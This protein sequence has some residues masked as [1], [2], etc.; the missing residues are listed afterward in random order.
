MQRLKKT[1]L[2][3][4]CLTLILPLSGRSQYKDFVKKETRS[5]LFEVAFDKKT[6][7][8][9]AFE[10]EG[11]KTVVVNRTDIAITPSDVIISTD[12]S[13]TSAGLNFQ[14]TSLPYSNITDAFISDED[15]LTTVTFYS[16]N[17]PVSRTNQMHGG[18]IISF[19]DP[20]SVKSGEFVRGLIF[21]VKGLITVGGEVNKD[22]ISLFGD[23][24]LISGA[25]ARGN[26]VSI[27]GQID[28]EKNASLYGEVYSGTK[29][30]DSR[31][32]RF[33]TDSEFEPG[34]MLN[35]NRVDGLLL[36]GKLSFVDADSA[37]P[38]AEI[39]LGYA[40]ESERLR[41]S[42]KVSHTLA[43]KEGLTIGAE[44]Y[45]KLESED[46]RL[47]SN[48]E[49]AVFVFLATEDF[50]DYYESEGF[51]AWIGLE[52]IK[53]LNL[54]TGFHFDDTRW[55]RSRRQ[56]WSM[57]GGSKIFRENF[58]SVDTSFRNTGVA[59]LNSSETGA[60]F[61]NV[62]Y[63][64]RNLE[65]DSNLSGWTL[66]GD[67]EW[68]NRKIAS[69]Y[70]YRRFSIS[71]IRYQYLN[72]SV[73]LRMRG[74]FA[75]SDGYLPMYKRYFIGGLGTLQ[76][77]KHKEFMGTRYWMT[78]SEFWLKLPTT[79]GVHLV[80]AWDVAQIA[81]D[82]KLDDNAEIRHD[83]GLGIS[84]SSFKFDVTKRL[85][86]YPDRDPRIYVRFARRF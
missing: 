77:Y 40:L 26:I 56:M 19:S 52:P 22:I 36:G 58:S 4:L 57:F 44:L 49:N 1:I 81:N 34:V 17:K 74:Q 30:F 85:D 71:A 2:I 50:K 24:S 55:L 27:T 20:I 10:G 70:D 42:V 5:K 53:R 14:G 83:L 39:G 73:N 65:A 21:S 62:K 48:A 47:L 79:F 64:S 60:I 68:S 18:N 25:V 33:N 7:T 13:F 59:E 86:S 37:I 61:L 28:V 3:A 23:V 78:N 76:G 80:L 29:N 16:S 82:A 8:V 32:F 46:N 6:L 41:Y 54:K 51:A 12:V 15:N 69:D 11:K 43:R 35:Y 38:S 75:N 66:A 9:S 63:D 45:Q 67:L 31:R 84:I 72:K